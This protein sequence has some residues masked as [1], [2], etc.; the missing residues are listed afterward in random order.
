M[1]MGCGNRKG[2][3]AGCGNL[4]CIPPLICSQAMS[5]K[6]VKPVKFCPLSLSYIVR[7]FRFYYFRRFCHVE[8][9][10]KSLRLQVACIDLHW[11]LFCWRIWP[12]LLLPGQT[13]WTWTILWTARLLSKSDHG[14]TTPALMEV[15]NHDNV[16][17]IINCGLCI[18]KK[19]P[20]GMRFFRKKYLEL[21]FQGKWRPWKS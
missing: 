4:V 2:K 16:V 21:L 11:F 8:R 18:T 20:V 10:I 12:F 19:G 5:V 1:G 7:L 17:D 6:E 3:I 13:C 14:M 9:G 15:D